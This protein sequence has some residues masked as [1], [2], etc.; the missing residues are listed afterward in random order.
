MWPFLSKPKVENICK[1]AI[2]DWMQKNRP[3]IIARIN[4]EIEA[5]KTE[6]GKAKAE[7]QRAALDRSKRTT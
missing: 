7:S 5:Q 4:A 1:S 3:M 2:A 6:A